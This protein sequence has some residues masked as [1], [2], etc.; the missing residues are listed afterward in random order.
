MKTRLIHFVF[1]LSLISGIFSCS[2]SRPMINSID[3]GFSNYISAYSSG[4][5]QR[6]DAI[7]IELAEPSKKLMEMDSTDLYK[8]FNSEPSIKG[9]VIA[10]SDRIIEFVPSEPMKVNSFYTVTFNLNKITVVPS[11]YEKFTFQFATKRQEIDVEFDG[12]ENY[13]SYQIENQYLSGSISTTEVEDTSKVRKIIQAKLDGKPVAIKWNDT[14]D[15]SNY[16]V[17]DSLKRTS[18]AQ[19]L[20]VSWNGNSIQSMNAGS[21]EFIIPSLGD[22]TVTSQDLK[23]DDNQKI[24]LVFSDPL[25]MSQNLNGIINIKG[26][27]NLTYSINRNTVS[28]YLPNRFEGTFPIEITTGIK[29]VAGFKMDSI[30]Q[31][32]IYLHEAYPKLKLKG[33]GTILP[34]SQGLIFPFEAIAL[35]SVTVR[36]IKIYEKNVHYFLQVNNLNGSDELTRFGKIIAEKKITLKKD[37]NLKQWNTHI[38][39][40]ENLIKPEPGA[41][42]QISIKF[43]KADITCDCPATGENEESENNDDEISD[44][45]WNEYNW[46]SYGFD[47]Y[48]TWGSDDNEDPCSR[49]Y[50]YGNAVQTNILAS[51]IGMIFKLD[52]DKTSHAFISDMVTTEPIANAT[53]TYYDYVKNIIATATTN[54][55]GMATIQLKEKPFL[56]IATIGN[57]KGYLKLTDGLVNSLSKFDVSGEMIQKGVKGFIYAERSVWRP[58][59]SL[60]INFMLQDKLKTL[61]ENHP[62]KFEFFDPSG[63][64]IYQHSRNTHLNGVYDFRTKTGSE[65]PTGNYRGVVSIGNKQYT[66]YFKVETIK[67]NRLKISMEANKG[68]LQDSCYLQV[69]WL[70]GASAKDLKATVSMYLAPIQTKIKGFNDYHFD[71]PIRT[72]SSDRNTVFDGVLDGKGRA[73]FKTTYQNMSEAAGM[74]QANFITKV[75]EKSGNF[76]ID[77][78]VASFSPFDAYVGLKTPKTSAYDNTLSTDKKHI[79]D[80]V[81]VDV[82]GKFVSGHKVKVQIFKIDWNWWYD[83]NES[84]LSS[85]IGRNS[86]ILIKEQ[87]VTTVN[88]KA[89]IE[90]DVKYPDYGS[91]IVLATDQQSK[92]QTGEMVRIDWPYWNRTNRS[93]NE[94]ASMLSF[95]LDKKSYTKGEVIKITFPSP[96]AGRALISVETSQKVIKKF[97][98]AT[99]EGE[100]S[101][102]F[103]ATADMAPNAFIHVTM[104]QPHHA[105]KNDLPIRMYGVMP[106]LVDDP[107]THLHPMISMNDEIRPEQTTSI[108][109][110]EENGRKMTYTLD[111][112]DDGLLDLTAFKT[113]QPWD[114]FYAKEALGVQTWDM[115]ND[116]IGAYS[117]KMNNLYTIGGDAASIVGNGP[118]ANRFKPM[119][120][121]LGP[122]TINAGESKT[123]KVEIPSYMGSVRV[124]V[125]A[126]DN[127]A[128]GNAQKTVQ[129]KKPVMLLATL[130]RVLGPQEEFVLPVNVFAMNKSIKNVKLK[131]EVNEFFELIDSPSKS[132]QFNE[133]GDQLVNYKL[134]VK[135]KVGIGK[136]KIT[137]L[138]GNENAST[139]IE[140]D[141]RPANSLNY[142]VQE[143]QLEPGK[144]ISAQLLMDGLEG[145]NLGTIELSTIPA[146]HLEKRLGYLINYPHGCL[147]QTTSAVFPQLFLNELME[148][149]TKEQASVTANIKAGLQ[150]LQSFQT[151]DGGLAYWAGE[152]YSNEWATNYAGHFMLE[153]EALGYKLPMNIKDNWIRYQK[154]AARNWSQNYSA[155]SYQYDSEQLTQAYRLFLLAEANQPEIGSMNRLREEKTL[156]TTAKWRLASAYYIIGQ[157]E[158][159]KKLVQSAE[160]DVKAYKELSGSF[161]SAKRDRAVILEAMSCM[162]MNADAFKEM[163]IVAKELSSKNWMS[164]QE[165]G[166][167]L[168]AIAKFTKGFDGSGATD[169]AITLNSDG[170]KSMPINKRIIKQFVVAKQGMSKQSLSIKNSGNGVLFVTVTTQKIPLVGKEKSFNNKLNM[171]VNYTD[172]A[173]KTISVD[174]LKQGQ[175][176]VA[177]VTLHNPSKTEF[178]SEMALSHL[179]PS[180]WEV[181]NARLFGGDVQG[182]TPSDRPRYQDI[183]DDRVFSYFSLAPEKSITISIQL[184]A[185]FLGKFYLPAIYAEAMYDHGISAQE[186]GKW[187]NV[188]Q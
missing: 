90:F 127:D 116:V 24:E 180:G 135:N 20:I 39:N 23:E 51:N 6:D 3:P 79:F 113:P 131:I 53:V 123:H 188:V 105:T 185:S 99:K 68:S 104:I 40:L 147:E 128:Y 120:V 35:K 69:N 175:E 44:D 171:T 115:Y 138:S 93:E 92:H 80:I 10:I 38:I 88:G 49:S 82:N 5:I 34:N 110:K 178:Y 62:V 152:S 139:E 26:I 52:E 162:K 146:I 156:S 37:L 170:V 36:V 137:G 4:I 132:V 182:I 43:D 101:H 22:F 31:S 54:S 16:F 97:W 8:L 107:T 70:H 28:V 65:S 176:F 75:F 15:N 1:I 27:D 125:V 56:M 114:V 76:S 163:K 186:A 136:I 17:I 121:H 130:P 89:Q 25:D 124:M 144:S 14:Y 133:V 153:A 94:F 96:S 160:K 64:L 112:V 57:Q 21:K 41:I 179:F 183:R 12:I 166:Y 167:S 148:L 60:F 187:V 18:K 33:N 129:V 142:E 169:A 19:K 55:E 149:S 72:A 103:E 168:M 155:N 84:D 58:G 73:E 102:T 66:K 46:H 140:I 95:S 13:N 141:I 91:Y 173:G 87:V 47:G 151:S 161:G 9:R 111:I 181:H 158:T 30:Y 184:N 81:N 98:I 85:F 143:F 77:R 164:T 11:Q 145:T 42:Y 32:E 86:T 71:S 106:V 63:N 117:G 172:F 159:A 61:P 67:P 29:N 134:K 165:T 48:S 78:K 50:Y 108:T 74:M 59:D 157:K 45:E 7:R 2:K 109:V 122:F 174:N 119:V 154:N 177:Q 118:K 83:S 126:R 100:T 150:R